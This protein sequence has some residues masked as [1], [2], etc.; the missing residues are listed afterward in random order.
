MAAARNPLENRVSAG[1]LLSSERAAM[2]HFLEKIA[3]YGYPGLFAALVLGIAGLPIPDETLLVFCGYLVARGSMHPLLTWITAV[4][5]SMSGITVSYWIGR[6]AGHEVVH[7][8]GRYVHLTEDRLLYVQHWFDRIGH[9]LLTIGY[10]IPGVRHFT[11]VVAG[12]SGMRYRAFAPYAYSGAV[13]WVSTFLGIGY[14]LGDR[15]K[16]VFEGL[17]KDMLIVI[18][19]GTI[20]AWVAWYLVSRRKTARAAQTP[21]VEKK[22]S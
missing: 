1:V 20:V 4:A 16:Q 15:W 8:F 21:P 17:H 14:V 6:F 18:V 12:M 7:R 11:A 2:D 5:G 19:A 9:W 3:Q 13:L 22:D 10:Y